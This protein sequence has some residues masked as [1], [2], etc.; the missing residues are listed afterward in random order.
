MKRWQIPAEEQMHIRDSFPLVTST[1]ALTTKLKRKVNTRETDA[2]ARR[3]VCT[4]QK[5][6]SNDYMIIG[7]QICNMDR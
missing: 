5:N 3:E 7:V 6:G 4:A 1:L 2:N